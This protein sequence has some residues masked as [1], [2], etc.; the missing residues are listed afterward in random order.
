MG[1]CLVLNVR[2][3][4]FLVSQKKIK[5]KGKKKKENY[6]RWQALKETPHEDPSMFHELP[7][8]L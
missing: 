2:G 1:F 4:Q 3:R 5:N 6:R 7:T 8:V